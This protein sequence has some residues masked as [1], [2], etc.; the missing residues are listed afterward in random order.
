LVMWH[1]GYLFLHQVGNS[2]D[3]NRDLIFKVKERTHMFSRTIGK[4]DWPD[5]SSDLSKEASIS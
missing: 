5:D 4:K 3:R 1:I 2:D